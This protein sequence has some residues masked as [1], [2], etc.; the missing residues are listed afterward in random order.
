MTLLDGSGCSL[1]RVETMIYV[2]DKLAFSAKAQVV[3]IWVL[4][5]RWSADNCPEVVSDSVCVNKCGRVPVELY[6]RVKFMFYAISTRQEIFSPFL[7]S[8]VKSLKDTL[9]L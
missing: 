4:L 8:S 7:F 3:N 5:D 1:A 9:S 2:R 6:G